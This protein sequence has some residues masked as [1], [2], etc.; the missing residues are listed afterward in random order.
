MRG[1]TALEYA[2]LLDQRAGHP[3]FGHAK[4]LREAIDKASGGDLSSIKPAIPL[5][6]GA[7]ITAT[8]VLEQIADMVESNSIDAFKL[9]LQRNPA[10]VNALIPGDFGNKAPAGHYAIWAGHWEL[11]R[12]WVQLGGDVKIKGQGGGWVSK[13]DCLEYAR[14]LDS[15][16]HPYYKFAENVQQ[17]SRVQEERKD[18]SHEQ[19]IGNAGGQ[20]MCAICLDRPATHAFVPCFHLCVCEQD[21]Q[22]I[23]NADKKCPICRASSSSLQAVYQAGVPADQ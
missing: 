19:R 20:N 6:A 10:A 13:G 9:S 1:K 8:D 5:N 11:F 16:G 12:V 21:G 17:A 15:K 18:D 22:T 23:L 2:T 4:S 3:F 14:F 7:D